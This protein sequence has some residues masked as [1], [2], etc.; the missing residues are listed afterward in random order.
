MSKETRLIAAVA[1]IVVAIIGALLIFG[2][3][4][5]GAVEVEASA[6]SAVD[7]VPL[8]SPSTTA[9]PSPSTSAASAT[10]VD[11]DTSPPTT[12]GGPVPTM[13]PGTVSIQSVADWQGDVPADTVRSRFDDAESSSDVCTRLAALT[14][15]PN[16]NSLSETSAPD[17]NEFFTRWQALA[18]ETVPMIDAPESQRLRAA[19]SA[20]LTIE[21]I[22][23]ESGGTF[24]KA[25]VDQILGDD[26]SEL[27]QLLA[28]FVLVADQCP[29]PPAG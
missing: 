4:D 1:V 21:Q 23:N 12:T 11:G 20:M 16:L 7:A 9:T 18:D 6:T 3:D 15:L 26:G 13:A 2:G 10:G 28:L 17:L 24:N 5:E 22:V 25:A 19:R 8:T 14:S 27:T 29:A